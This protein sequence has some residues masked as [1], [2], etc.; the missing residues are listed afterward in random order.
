MKMWQ[1]L[2]YTQTTRPLGALGLDSR[3]LTGQL[4][5]IYRLFDLKV[6]V[7]VAVFLVLA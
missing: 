2:C 6:M 4:L 1:R 7:T 5:Q 3:G